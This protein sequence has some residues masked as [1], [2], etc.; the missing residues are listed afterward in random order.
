[1]TSAWPLAPARTGGQPQRRTD[2]WQT[3]AIRER[4]TER[5]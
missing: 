5:K 1:M 2:K 4:M 3:L